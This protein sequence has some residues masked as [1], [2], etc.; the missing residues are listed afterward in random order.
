MSATILSRIVSLDALIPR[1]V[2]VGRE[3]RDVESLTPWVF[4]HTKIAQEDCLDSWPDEDLTSSMLFDELFSC[5]STIRSR[6]SLHDE[7]GIESA[8]SPSAGITL[9]LKNWEVKAAHDHLAF[10]RAQGMILRM[11]MKTVYAS[12]D[13]VRKQDPEVRFSIY[14]SK[15]RY[16]IVDTKY[17]ARS[18]GEV[19]WWIGQTWDE[20]LQETLSVM[21]GQLAQNLGVGKD[22]SLLEEQEVFLVGFHGYGIHI[23]RGAF[24]RDA[25]G[26]VY[27]RGC[28][29]DETF[30]VQFTRG[31]NLCQKE[32]WDDAM[33]ALTRL[34]RYLLSGGAKVVTF[35]TTM[36]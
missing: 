36:R 33:R 8:L 11:L 2:D 19:T 23:A 1:V 25:V 31:Y 29:G 32:E 3:E 17:S 21:L 20:F 18:E 5:H 35:P 28:S 27:S 13:D 22:D 30:E 34:F 7:R 12:L 26:R 16:V 6:S 9:P 24:T 14:A 15:M 10:T 4:Q